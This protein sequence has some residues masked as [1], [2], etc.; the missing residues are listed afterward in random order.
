M[1]TVKQEGK[2]VTHGTAVCGG[3]RSQDLEVHQCQ[4]QPDV[5]TVPCMLVIH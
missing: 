4:I 1:F 3:D 5:P 2:V